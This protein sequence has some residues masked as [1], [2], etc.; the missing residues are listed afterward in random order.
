MKPLA[1]S[2]LA[3]YS[4]CIGW[5]LFDVP[6]HATDLTGVWATTAEACKGMFVKKG[7]TVSFAKDSDAYGI[8]FILEKDRIRGKARAC[9]ITKTKDDGP[10]RHL[11]ANCTTGVMLEVVQ[12][13]LKIED[14]NTITRI[15]PGLP[16][17]ATSYFRCSL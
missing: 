5:L 16:E 3:L 6:A 2:R 8:G 10:V 4:V 15:F 13:S 11:I 1:A 12:Y 7:G 9:K 17:L 14:E